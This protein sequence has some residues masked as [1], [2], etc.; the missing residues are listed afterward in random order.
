MARARSLSLCPVRV[1]L[2]LFQSQVVGWKLGET[3][4][5]AEL[6]VVASKNALMLLYWLPISTYSPGGFWWGVE[7]VRR[8]PLNRSL[9]RVIFLPENCQK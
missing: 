1:I 8:L 9:V 3:C 7:T 2:D 5:E 6:V 4:L